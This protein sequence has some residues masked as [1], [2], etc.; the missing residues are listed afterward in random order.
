M[1]SLISSSSNDYPNSQCN[2]TGIQSVTAPSS[3][4]HHRTMQSNSLLSD[5][6]DHRDKKS[7][8][9]KGNVLQMEVLN[10][11]NNNNKLTKPHKISPTVVI[12]PPLSNHQILSS[13]S[14]STTSLSAMSSV[15]KYRLDFT[16][17]L[18]IL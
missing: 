8:H 12:A 9:N 6:S 3:S 18:F 7:S 17:F 16:F 1:Y 13:N 14:F 4:Y 10:S 11:N 2:P 15:I 5:H